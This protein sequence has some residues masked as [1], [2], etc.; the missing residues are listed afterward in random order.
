MAG[1]AGLDAG[2][3]SARAAGHGEADW[4]ARKIRIVSKSNVTA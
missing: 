3:A 1:L 4:R 2:G